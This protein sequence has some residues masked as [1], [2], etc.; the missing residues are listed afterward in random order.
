MLCVVVVYCEMLLGSVPCVL[1]AI[2]LSM[3]IYSP[4]DVIEI[5]NRRI[6]NID[7][8]IQNGLVR[9]LIEVR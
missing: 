1:F 7:W 9:P 8:T 2:I 3:N 6:Y 4:L 5:D